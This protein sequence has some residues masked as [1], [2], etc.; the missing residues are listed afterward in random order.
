M[1]NK[2]DALS[3]RWVASQELCVCQYGSFLSGTGKTWGTVIA[4]LVATAAVGGLIVLV[5]TTWVVV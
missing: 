5:T 4:A 1:G 2:V 3:L